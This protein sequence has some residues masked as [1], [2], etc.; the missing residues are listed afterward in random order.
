M[1][2][3]CGALRSTTLVIS[4][5]SIGIPFLNVFLKYTGF[6][7]QCTE[8]DDAVDA[9][10]VI[11]NMVVAVCPCYLC[12]KLDKAGKEFSASVANADAAMDAWASS[13]SPVPAAED[14][15]P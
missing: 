10:D 3:G 13:L 9:A 11:N 4:I 8:G 15:D 5:F 7:R 2:A 12:Y 14:D 1:D 6:K